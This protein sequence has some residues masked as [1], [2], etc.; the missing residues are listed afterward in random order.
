MPNGSEMP[1]AYG[2][3]SL[4]SS[5]L[6]YSQIDKEALSIVYGVKHFHIIICMVVTLL[7]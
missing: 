7:L 4:Q 6:N 3:R 2:S 1:I 5:E